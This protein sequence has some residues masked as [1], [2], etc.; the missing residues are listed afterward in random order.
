VGGARQPSSESLEAVCGTERESPGFWRFALVWSALA[1]AI[2]LF[3]IAVGIFSGPSDTSST[4]QIAWGIVLGLL[5]LAG[6]LQLARNGTTSNGSGLN[7]RGLVLEGPGTIPWGL[8]QGSVAI[9][10][11]KIPELAQLWVVWSPRHEGGQAHAFPVPSAFHRNS[12]ATAHATATRLNGELGARLDA[13]EM[14][15][16]VRRQRTVPRN[17]YL[18]CF[19]MSLL[20]AG[21]GTLFAL[22]ILA[23]A[24]MSR[25]LWL[26]AWAALDLSCLMLYTAYTDPALFGPMWTLWILLFWPG[27]AVFFLVRTV[28]S[29]RAERDLHPERSGEA[30]AKRRRVGKT[31]FVV[32]LALAFV[33]ATGALATFFNGR[34]DAQPP[35]PVSAQTRTSA[36]AALTPANAAYTTFFDSLNGWNS[37]TTWNVAAAQAKPLVVAL[38]NLSAT[39]KRT[40]W[41]PQ[42]SSDVHTLLGDDAALTKVLERLQGPGTQSPWAWSNSSE[43]MNSSVNISVDTDT[44]LNDL[45]F[46]MGPLGPAK[47]QSFPDFDFQ[48]P[49]WS[50][51]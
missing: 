42:T 13:A 3:F 7:R 40:T 29:R 46:P 9:P 20:G 25:W 32:V 1:F 23:L 28:E 33:V 48:T 26:V 47:W 6:V 22:F 35:V 41:P 12:A 21:F 34:T 2:P 24:K 8:I 18:G 15:Q 44:F 31:T 14:G 37:G 38:R 16:V 30:H 39:L 50:K 45:G 51:A 43:F 4:A 49:P 10:D 27:P 5:A 36:L 19:V 11:D 17:V